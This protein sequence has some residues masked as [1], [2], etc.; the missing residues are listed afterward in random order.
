M[1][2]TLATLALVAGVVSAQGVTETIAPP[3]N[4]PAGCSTT[5]GS[6]FEIT[7]V[8]PTRK[9]GTVEVSRQLALYLYPSLFTHC[10]DRDAAASICLRLRWHPRCFTDKRRPH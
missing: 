4:P 8:L 2:F 1:Q 10:A 9:R 3:G 5:Y 6:Q 7:V